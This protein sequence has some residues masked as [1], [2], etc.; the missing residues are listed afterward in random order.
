MGLLPAFNSEAL[1]L[2]RRAVAA[3]ETIAEVM[4][5]PPLTFPPQCCC[6]PEC[7]PRC[8]MCADHKHEQCSLR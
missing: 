6:G 3:L 5:T 7:V 4:S 2:A 8:A 1:D